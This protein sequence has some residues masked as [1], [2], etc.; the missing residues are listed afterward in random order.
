VSDPAEYC[1]EIE[2]YLCQKNE[3]HLIRIVGPAFELVCSWEKQGVPLKVAFRG[4]D[5][6]CERHNAK[7]G[8]RRPVRIDFCEADIRD[9]F[10]DWRRAVGVVGT[11][12]D[13][14]PGAPA[15][16]KTALA[17]H[18][19]GAIS[20][21]RGLTAKTGVSS[22]L[23]A[24]VE[25]VV[26]ELEALAAAAQGARGERRA[27]IVGRLSELDRELLAASVGEIHSDRARELKNE[28]EMELAPFRARMPADAHERAIEAAYLR[29]VR[30]ALGV[31]AVSYE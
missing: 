16:R 31:P 13:V 23:I 22:E 26:T 21:L 12:T 7:A 9:A 2:T 3:G 29:L 30:Q 24:R 10:D 15:H 19:D 4:I 14:E 11:A 6:C 17:S 25:R 28:A 8:R 5:R 1:R 18:I 20:R 27:R